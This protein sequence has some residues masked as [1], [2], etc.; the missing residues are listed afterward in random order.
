M[1]GG[2]HG[3]A[4]ADRVLRTAAR[5]L[6]LTHRHRPDRGR[7]PN[8][9]GSSSSWLEPESPA[10]PT[11]LAGVRLEVDPGEH[12]A[13]EVARYEDTVAPRRARRADGP[14]HGGSEHQIDQLV[15]VQR[16]CLERPDLEAVAQHGH[17]AGDREDLV[18]PVRDVEDAQPLLLDLADRREQVLDLGPRHVA[19]GSSSTRIFADSSESQRARAIATTVRSAAVSRRRGAGRRCPRS[20]ARRA[21]CGRARARPPSGSVR[22]A[23]GEPA[24]EREVLDQVQRVDEGQVLM[25]EP[26]ARLARG[27]GG[28]EADLLAGDDHRRAVL[29]AVESG[30]QLDQGRLARPVLPDQG[31]DLALRDVE[32]DR[33]Q[34]ASARERLREVVT[35]RIGSSRHLLR[36]RRRCRCGFD[37]GRPPPQLHG[38]RPA[39]ERDRDDQCGAF[40]QRLAP[41]APLLELSA[42]P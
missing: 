18:E 33:V 25:D 27:G 39:G 31:M 20:R 30:Q 8:N 1:I 15:L 22:P 5:D 34:G 26:E 2:H 36:T 24:A 9:I 14:E 40:E 32:T 38:E 12:R 29:G 6:V 10:N 16:R 7:A 13:A 11:D 28:P 41:Y 37:R 35:W 19:V 4:S 17:A 23:G 42:R 21:C 3:H